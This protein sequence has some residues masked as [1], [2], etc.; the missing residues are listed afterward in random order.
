MIL[1]IDGTTT[2]STIP[3]ATTNASVQPSHGRAVTVTAGTTAFGGGEQ[4]VTIAIA[5]NGGIQRITFP[6]HHLS[7]S[8]ES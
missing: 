6:I 4:A 7:P 2:T 1:P 8:R 3:F 5:R